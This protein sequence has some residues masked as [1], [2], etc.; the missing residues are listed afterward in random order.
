M[1]EIQTLRYETQHTFPVECKVLQGVSV[2]FVAD[3]GFGSFRA[4]RG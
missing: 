2:S 1:S 4:D 3:L